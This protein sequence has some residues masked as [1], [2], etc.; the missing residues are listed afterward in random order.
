[1]GEVARARENAR[2]TEKAKPSDRDKTYIGLVDMRAAFDRLDRMELL[3]LMAQ[4]PIPPEVTTAVAKIMN[5]TSFT[6]PSGDH[7]GSTGGVC[8]I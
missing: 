3:T 5:S 7:T 8:S 6:I 1:M 2:R 4:A